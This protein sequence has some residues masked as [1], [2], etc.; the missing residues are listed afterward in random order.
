M[1]TGIGAAS[2]CCLI[3]LVPTVTYGI[4]A[5]QLATTLIIP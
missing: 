4:S 2:G 3:F 1:K 5:H